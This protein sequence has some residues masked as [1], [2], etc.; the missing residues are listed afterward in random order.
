MFNCF[1]MTGAISLPAVN[2]V[3]N[4]NMLLWKNK[5]INGKAWSRIKLFEIMSPRASMVVSKQIA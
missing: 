2:K 5:D 1:I 4:D 3:S